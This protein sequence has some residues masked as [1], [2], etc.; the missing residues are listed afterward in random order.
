MGLFVGLFVGV[1][2]RGCL[3]RLFVGVGCGVVCG[4]CL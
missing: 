3:W 1:V 2:C 4:G